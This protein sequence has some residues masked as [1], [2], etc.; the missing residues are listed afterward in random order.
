M[1]D[2]VALEFEGGI[3]GI[4]GGGFVGVTVFV[5]A[6][7][8]MGHG[9]A[10][11]RLDRGDHVVEHVAPVAEHVRDHAAAVLLAVVPRRALRRH[12]VPF[13]DPIA[14]FTAHAEN[15]AEKT[16][17]AQAL[18]LDET[19][20]IKFVMHDAVLDAL[21]LGMFGNRDGLFQPF[22]DRLFRIDMLAR[23]DRL[24]QQTGAH[25]G[26]GGV[27]EDGVIGVGQRGIEIGGVTFDA[28]FG[29]QLGDL[30]FV[31]ADD[32]HVGHQTITVF[33]QHAAPIADRQNRADQVL[34]HPH[35][36]GNTMHDD[37]DALLCHGLFPCLKSR[38]AIL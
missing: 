32:D 20:Q 31:A 29:G 17:V 22:R 15:L 36:S 38:R 4:I 10:G 5:P 1:G 8:D 27:K 26:A 23:V 9:V 30:L 2:D 7:G 18:E 24:A 33:Q 28:V 35:P 6:L 3:G 12:P 37:A 11:H 19:G 14:E 13:E 21:G 16:A 25:L 34:V